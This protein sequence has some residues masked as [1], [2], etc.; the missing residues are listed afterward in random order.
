MIPEDKLNMRHRVKALLNDDPPTRDY[1]FRFKFAKEKALEGIKD[2][3]RANARFRKEKDFQ[4]DDEARQSMAGDLIDAIEGMDEKELAEIHAAGFRIDPPEIL[5]T[6]AL[7]ILV[8]LCDLV[9][10]AETLLAADES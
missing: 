10:E 9:F 2:M 4:F 1:E 6:N 8:E 7:V 3:M 5:S